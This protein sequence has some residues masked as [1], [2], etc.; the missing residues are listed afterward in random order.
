MKKILFLTFSY[1]Y[2]HFGPSDQCTTR[3]METLVRTGK[4]EVHNVSFSGD[5]NQ[6]PIIEGVHIHSLSLKESIQNRPAWLIR[7]LLMLKLPHYPYTKRES[8]KRIYKICTKLIESEQYDLVVAQNNPEESVMV[9]TWLKKNG[10]IDRLMIIFWD[11]IYGKL[12]RRVI[13]KQFALRRQFEAENKIAEYADL[14]VSLYPLK[15]FHNQYG[16]V[17]N[18]LGKRDY[19][20]I[21]SVTHPKSLGASSYKHVIKEDKI[22]M[23]YSGTIFRSE[24]VAYL[25]ELLNKTTYAESINLIFFSRGVSESDFANYKNNF[26]GTIHL[27]GWIPIN[28]LL[29]LYPDVDYFLSFPGN[30]TAICSKVYEYM[31]YGKPLVLLYDDDND[32]NVS[33]FSRYP[34]CLS[35][36]ERL[37]SDKHIHSLEEYIMRTKNVS[38]SFEEVEKLFPNDTAS[39]YQNL[40]ESMI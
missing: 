39:A 8:S 9:G 21:P 13:P 16:D 12:P 31:S 14:L 33:T 23:L 1:P 22:N 29:S 36:D 17:P 24:Y 20:G 2:G 15:T 38:I 34:A 28:D 37:A 26:K 25:V 32:V 30:P 40:I 10:Y 5:N 19:L 35:L 11:A 27:S 7:L 6:Y 18:A 4:Y 3:I